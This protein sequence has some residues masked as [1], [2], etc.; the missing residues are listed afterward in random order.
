MRDWETWGLWIVGGGVFFV[1]VARENPNLLLIAGLF[2]GGAWERTVTAAER[3][4]RV[5]VPKR[6]RRGW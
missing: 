2:L 4:F 5:R 3:S 1:A 6:L